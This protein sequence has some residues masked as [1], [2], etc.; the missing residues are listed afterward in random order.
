M[1]QTSSDFSQEIYE[2]KLCSGSFG[3]AFGCGV[4]AERRSWES[5]KLEHLQVIFALLSSVTSV[6]SVGVTLLVK[7]SSQ[8]LL[9]AIK[10]ERQWSSQE[11]LTPRG[12]MHLCWIP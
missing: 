11:I 8:A 10:I 9:L 1:L 5:L 12:G 2:K 3:D 7:L 4:P 6:S